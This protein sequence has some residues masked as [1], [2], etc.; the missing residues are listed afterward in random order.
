MAWTA[1][2]LLLSAIE[3][4]EDL[5]QLCDVHVV[6]MRAADG[7]VRTLLACILAKASANLHAIA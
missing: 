7:K 6:M 5:A 1:G 2:I 4:L 3:M